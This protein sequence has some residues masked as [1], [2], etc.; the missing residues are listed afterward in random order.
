MSNDPDYLSCKKQE[1]KK[2]DKNGKCVRRTCSAMLSFHVVNIR[3]EIE[4]VAFGGGFENPCVIKRSNSIGFANPN[5]PL[6]GHVSSIDSTSTSVS[7]Y[8][9]IICVWKPV[10]ATLL[11]ILRLRTYLIDMKM[12]VLISYYFAPTTT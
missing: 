8:L 4:F 1:C 11:V 12:L 6:Y 2:Y 7:T 3:T 10:T 9:N 5:M